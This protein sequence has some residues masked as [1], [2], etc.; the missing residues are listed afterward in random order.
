[1]SLDIYFSQLERICLGELYLDWHIWI[2]GSWDYYIDAVHSSYAIVRYFD[3]EI[4]AKV[5]NQGIYLF[6]NWLAFYPFLLFLLSPFHFHHLPIQT[7]TWVQHSRMPTIFVRFFIL[8]R[9]LLF[10]GSHFLHFLLIFDWPIMTNLGCYYY[11]NLPWNT[12]NFVL[13]FHH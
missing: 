9:L 11:I 5:C 8:L 3:L 1:M 13:L 6:S 2:Y 7:V 4:L 12:I 10:L